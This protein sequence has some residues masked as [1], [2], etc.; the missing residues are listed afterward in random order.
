MSGFQ[1]MDSRWFKNKARTAYNAG[2]SAAKKAKKQNLN[3]W[4]IPN[5]YD[6]KNDEINY[7]AWNRGFIDE[8]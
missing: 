2:K 3:S 4:E 6:L 8:G 5:P 7:W 1:G